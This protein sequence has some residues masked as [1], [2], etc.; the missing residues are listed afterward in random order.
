MYRT[1]IGVRTL[2]G[3]ERRLFVQSLGMLTD[4][5][6]DGDYEVGVD[7]FDVLQRGQKIAVLLGVSRALLRDNVPPP[8]LTAVAEAAVAC[9]FR[10][11]AGRV[12]DEL[13]QQGEWVNDPVAAEGFGEEA[14]NGLESWRNLILAAGRETLELKKLPDAAS[15][16]EADWELLIDCL[17]DRVLWDTDWELAAPLDADPEQGSRWKE[18]LGIDEDY[19]VSLPP[20]PSDK[21]AARMIEELR[22]LT[23]EGRGL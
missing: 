9:V 4:Y 7:L 17:Q 10:H 11:I 16:D 15:C 19:Y 23:P 14:E 5:L 22:F 2:K 21:E 3:A 8:E 12:E 1:S 18:E 6:T 13:D 20:D